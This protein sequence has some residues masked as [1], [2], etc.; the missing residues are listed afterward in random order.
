M[1]IKYKIFFYVSFIF[2]VF[3]S[4]LWPYY[5]RETYLLTFFSLK[6]DAQFYSLLSDVSFFCFKKVA[7]LNSGDVFVVVVSFFL[8]RPTD[9]YRCVFDNGS[10]HL[11]LKRPNTYLFPKWSPIVLTSIDSLIFKN[12]FYIERS[13]I[14]LSIKNGA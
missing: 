5:F 3:L 1:R 8:K 6:N 12:N 4:L 14:P 10:L 13:V 2:H 9:A 11:F 7:I